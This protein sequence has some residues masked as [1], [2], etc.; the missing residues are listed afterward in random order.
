VAASYQINPAHMA[1]ASFG[2]GVESEVAPGRSRYTNAGEAL[3]ALT[4]KQ[5]EIGVKG[6][7]EQ[8]RWTAA[9]F[10]ITRPMFGDLGS[11]STTA[12]CTRQV[13]GTAQHNGVELTLSTPA[14]SA[15][16]PWHVDGGVT[17]IN[18]KRQGSTIDASQNGLRP[19]NVPDWILRLNAAYKITA[20]PGLA[21]NAHLSHEGKR[22]VLPDNSINIPAWTRLD[23]GASYVTKVGNSKT[24]WSFGIENVL[25]KSYFKESPYQFS[26]VYLFPGAP[27][28]ARL[29][30]Q[31]DL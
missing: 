9:W 10:D 5:F 27:R 20:V 22:A 25:N 28:T 11:C 7:L 29:S 4:S 1:Y 14:A 15:T 16:Q 24:T 18:A 8:W 23:L 21:L 2:Q 6:E 12:T 31:I 19:T 13:D 26:H 3:P 30:V 17:V